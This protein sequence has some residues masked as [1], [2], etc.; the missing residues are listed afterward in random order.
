M[1]NRQQM[2]AR[3]VHTVHVARAGKYATVQMKQQKTITF[4]RHVQQMTVF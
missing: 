3:K 2:T 1:R 4:G